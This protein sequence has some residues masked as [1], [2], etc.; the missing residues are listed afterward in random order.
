MKRL[1]LGVA[2]LVFGGLLAFGGGR[3]VYRARASEHWP[4]ARGS[5]LSSKVET[6]RSRRAVSFR[7]HVR[8]SY[9]VGAEGYTSETIAF[10]ALDTGNVQEANDYVRRFPAG[11]PVEL[12]YSPEDPSLACIECGQ[13]GMADYVVTVGGGALML[14]AALGLVDVLGSQLRAR[15]RQRTLA[16]RGEA[17]HQATRG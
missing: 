6:L 16:P 5:V 4:V 1:L 10:G 13:A 2:L 17:P 9:T 3:M 14:F 12:R 11:A 8:Y 7:P 15:R